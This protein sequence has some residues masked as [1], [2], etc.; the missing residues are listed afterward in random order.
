M[1]NHAVEDICDFNVSIIVNRN[2]FG[3]GAV[4]PLVVGD[5]PDV[6]R[7]FVDR[8]TWP[9]VDS[10]SLH[11]ASSSQNIRR[12]LVVVVRAACVEFQVVDLVF[13]RL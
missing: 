1:S 9:G 6:L 5:L 8:Q 3:A 4:L 10:L 11:G 2:H 12:P 7:Q 13:T